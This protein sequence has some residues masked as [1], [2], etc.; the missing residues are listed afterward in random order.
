MEESYVAHVS[1]NFRPSPCVTLSFLTQETAFPQTRGAER[2]LVE[3]YI[4]GP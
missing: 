3:D 2:K 4:R 1:F